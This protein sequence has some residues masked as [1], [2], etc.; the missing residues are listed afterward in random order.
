MFLVDDNNKYLWHATPDVSIHPNDPVLVLRAKPTASRSFA[1]SSNVKQFIPPTNIL[2]CA[3]AIARLALHAVVKRAAASSPSERGT[4][5]EAGGERQDG[6][7][8]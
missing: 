4:M 5:Y 8:R 6:G 2:L 1:L 3:M 7:L